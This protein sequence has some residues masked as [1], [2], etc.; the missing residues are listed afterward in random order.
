MALDWDRCLRGPEPLI[1]YS[2]IT[3]CDHWHRVEN[4]R[5]HILVVCLACECRKKEEKANG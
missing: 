5:T 3:C 1:H 4:H 2:A